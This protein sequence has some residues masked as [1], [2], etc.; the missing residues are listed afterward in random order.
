M[1]R[2]GKRFEVLNISGQCW[3]CSQRGEF[4]EKSIQ[5]EFFDFTGMKGREHAYDDYRI[6]AFPEIAYIGLGMFGL[7][8]YL[9]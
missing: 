2:L 4:A 3:C 9:I 5:S 6:D 1:V 8:K 7:E